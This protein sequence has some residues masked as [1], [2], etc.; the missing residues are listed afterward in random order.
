MGKKKKAS[1]WT[2]T[3]LKFLEE[4]IEDD[5]DLYLEEIHFVF[6]NYLSRW[7]FIFPLFESF[8]RVVLS[9]FRKKNEMKWMIKKCI[10]LGIKYKEEQEFFTNNLKFCSSTCLLIHQ[11]TK[12]Q[13][14]LSRHLSHPP[15]LA[16]KIISGLPLLGDLLRSSSLGDVMLCYVV[17]YYVTVVEWEGEGFDTLYAMYILPYIF[18]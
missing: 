13:F 14:L 5:P 10:G 18:Q 8:P 11:N 4:V 7:L 1:R 3:H 17:L 16:W 6:R 12:T 9:F 2:P 15:T